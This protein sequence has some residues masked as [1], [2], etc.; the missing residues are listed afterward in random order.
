MAAKK[1]FKSKDD[2][3]ALLQEATS[4]LG[5]KEISRKR[6]KGR[7][8]LEFYRDSTTGLRKY[9]HKYQPR[10]K[11]V[12]NTSLCSATEEDCDP[13]LDLGDD[14]VQPTCHEMSPSS[15][16]KQDDLEAALAKCEEVLSTFQIASSKNWETQISNL[17][18]SWDNIRKQ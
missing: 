3:D 4:L 14:D 10:K 2:L 12:T 7:S 17:T 15:I 11:K 16:V 5:E 8:D 9:K 13:S 18:S 6:R 1:A